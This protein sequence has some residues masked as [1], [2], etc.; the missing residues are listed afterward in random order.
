MVWL[1]PKNLQGFSLKKAAGEPWIQMGPAAKRGHPTSD[2]ANANNGTMFSIINVPRD[3]LG[4]HLVDRQIRTLLR[5]TPPTSGV[6][7]FSIYPLSL[8][9]SFALSLSLQFLPFWW[10]EI[11]R[12]WLLAVQPGSSQFAEGW[13]IGG[14]AARTTSLLH[15]R[16]APCGLIQLPH[17]EVNP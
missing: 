13:G 10:S 2:V 6:S 3:V 9:L 7:L 5:S 15:L 12:K 11:G 4:V 16:W 14:T 17:V 1:S 8:C